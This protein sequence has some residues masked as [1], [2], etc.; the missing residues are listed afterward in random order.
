MS[1]TTKNRWSTAG[2]GEGAWYA[3]LA[4]LVFAAASVMYSQL[5]KHPGIDP[6][7]AEVA[8]FAAHAFGWMGL[9]AAAGAVFLAAL[10]LSRTSGR[11]GS[12]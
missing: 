10:R 11:A 2:L 9:A 12:Q 6:Q 4:M 8:G 1:K 3:C 7:S 5:A